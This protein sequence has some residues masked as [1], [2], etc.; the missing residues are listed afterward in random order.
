MASNGRSPSQ[1]ETFTAGQPPWLALGVSL[2]SLRLGV[3]VEYSVERLRS[4]SEAAVDV[5]VPIQAS[6]VTNWYVQV[7]K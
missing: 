3:W 1:L 7:W 2:L 4:L 5:K 6:V